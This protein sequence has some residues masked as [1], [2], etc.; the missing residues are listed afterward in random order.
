MIWNGYVF[1]NKNDVIIC[2]SIKIINIWFSWLWMRFLDERSPRLTCFLCE[3]ISTQ[4][5]WN[6]SPFV[7]MIKM[8]ISKCETPDD[9]L[10]DIF[11]EISW[12]QGQ[13]NRRYIFDKTPLTLHQKIVQA[14]HFLSLYVWIMMHIHKQDSVLDEFKL[15][16]SF[17]HYLLLC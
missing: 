12:I 4:C 14:C 5:S 2:I 15:I 13:S 3:T 16:I 1:L 17:L 7:W 8:I 9:E 6:R 11:L 10:D